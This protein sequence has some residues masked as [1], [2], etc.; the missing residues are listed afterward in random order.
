MKKGAAEIASASTFL[1]L[2]Q[3][4]CCS[5]KPSNSFWL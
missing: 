4:I 2:K 5:V 3:E 1:M